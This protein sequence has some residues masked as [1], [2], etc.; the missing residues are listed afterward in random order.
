MHNPFLINY[1]CMTHGVELET[2]KLLL[3]LEEVAVVWR[4]AYVGS[5]WRNATKVPVEYS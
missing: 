1:A 2:A 3:S 4:D 5:D